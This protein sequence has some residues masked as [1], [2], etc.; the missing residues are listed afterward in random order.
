M[1]TTPQMSTSQAL[2]IR[3][4]LIMLI[5]VHGT[6]PKNSSSDVQHWMALMET[7]VCSIQRIDHRAELGHLHQRFEREPDRWRRTSGWHPAWPASASSSF[8]RMM[9]PKISE[10]SMGSTVM[11]LA[12]SSLLAVADGVER[13][14]TRA[15]GADAQA[16]ES[17]YHAADGGEPC[18]V[19]GELSPSRE[20]RCAAWSAS[21]ECRTASGYCRR[22]ILPQKLSR[23]SAMVIR[24]GVSGVAC[25]STGTPVGHA[26]GIGDGA[27]V[28]EVRQGHD[29]AVDRRSRCS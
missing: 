11:P 4:S 25:T 3:F 10:R 5:T 24:P 28:A 7:C 16:A 26:Q 15:D 8:M 29:D 12:S 14:G 9:R 22:V 6:T 21:R 13:R 23:R 17:A 1:P 20:L 2:D 18:Q 19:L 27:F